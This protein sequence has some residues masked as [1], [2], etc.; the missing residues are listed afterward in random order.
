MLDVVEVMMV[1]KIQLFVLI[2]AWGHLYL[3]R[4]RDLSRRIFSFRCS[5]S[6]ILDMNFQADPELMREMINLLG[7]ELKS[8]KAQLAEVRK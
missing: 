1:L 8:V 4:T 6:N 7:Q 3:Q 2:V 5:K